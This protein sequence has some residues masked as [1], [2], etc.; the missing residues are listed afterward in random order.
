MV[1]SISSTFDDPAAETAS[2]FTK[3]NFK[4][5]AAG[6]PCKALSGLPKYLLLALEEL[7]SG[8][9]RNSQGIALASMLFV[10]LL[11]MN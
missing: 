11:V 3:I 4:A 10:F 5:F 6:M 7:V 8:A 2:C 1:T 9:M